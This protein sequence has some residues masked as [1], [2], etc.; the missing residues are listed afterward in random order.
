MS[1]NVGIGVGAGA[2]DE[3][4]EGR[5]VGVVEAGDLDQGARVS[6]TAAADLDL[7]ALVVKFRVAALGAV[8]GD[9]LNA[10]EV[11]PGRGVAWEGEAHGGLVPGAPIAI[12]EIAVGWL[13]ADDRLVDLEPITVTTVLADVARGLGHVDG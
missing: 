10:D 3:E 4:A 9:V 13:A 8:D 7:R 6:G 2:V 11:L 12:L 1:T 5:V